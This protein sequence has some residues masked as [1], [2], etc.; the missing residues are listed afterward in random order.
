MLTEASTNDKSH[1]NY[2][3]FI[4]FVAHDFK[5]VDNRCFFHTMQKIEDESTLV[6]KKIINMSDC[7]KYWQLVVQS[8]L[9]DRD[10]LRS[11]MS[12]TLCGD[13]FEQKYMLL[14]LPKSQ[15]NA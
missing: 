7:C 9:G 14:L 6:K 13:V 4:G 2:D 5:D 10:K 3:G 1:K 11:N 12:V 8:I 15:G